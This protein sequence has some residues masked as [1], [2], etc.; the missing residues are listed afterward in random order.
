[1]RLQQAIMKHLRHPLRR[2]RLPDHADEAAVVAEAGR[3]DR[4]HQSVRLETLRVMIGQEAK[5]FSGKNQRRDRFLV[6]SGR[7]ARQ[8]HALADLHIGRVVT[9]AGEAVVV[10]A[11]PCQRLMLR[12]EQGMPAAAVEQ[13][14]FAEQFVVQQAGRTAVG[15][16]DA[17]LE[18]PVHHAALNRVERPDMHVQRY[19]RRLPGEQ[20][21]GVADARGRIAG[22]L[23]EY[24]H[25]E[26]AAEAAV[27]LVD[28]ADEGIGRRQQALGFH[29]DPLSLRRGGKTAASAMTKRQAEPR[30]QILHMLADGRNADIQFQLGRRHA[31]AVHHALEDPQQPHVG[32]AQLAENCTFF[33]LHRSSSKH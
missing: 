12:G 1:M 20:G 9:E 16:N 32:I 21:D 29:I 5:K 13:H 3:L 30:F 27:D 17:D 22:S 31:A 26:L 11:F 6:E 28:A 24:G 23:V 4:P 15:G 14:G 2:G 18:L 19:V 25:A 10:Q 33:Y 8:A 7:L